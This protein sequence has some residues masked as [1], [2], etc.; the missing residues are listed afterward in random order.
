MNLKIDWNW[1]L[2]IFFFFQNILFFQVFLSFKAAFEEN[3]GFKNLQNMGNIFFRLH[4]THF[5]HNFLEPLFS[6]KLLLLFSLFTKSLI[7]LLWKPCHFQKYCK[8]T[9]SNVEKKFREYGTMTC[10]KGQHPG[11][12]LKHPNKTFIKLCDFSGK[13]F[14]FEGAFLFSVCF[15][16]WDWIRIEWGQRTFR[17]LSFHFHIFMCSSILSLL[18]LVM[19]GDGFFRS[20]NLYH[21]FYEFF[22]SI[23]FLILNYESEFVEKVL[24]FVW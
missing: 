1:N 22:V 10:L 9:V 6:R 12:G 21:N 20:W 16:E 19:V 24:K 11:I 13:A 14:R 15:S 18:R 8:E 3:H 4:K 5:I 23:F 17:L 2:T 7:F